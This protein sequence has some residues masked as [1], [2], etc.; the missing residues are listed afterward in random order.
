LWGNYHKFHLE[1][2][3]LIR[4][5]AL[6]RINIRELQ[7]KIKFHTQK[8]QKFGDTAEEILSSRTTSKSRIKSDTWPTCHQKRE[9]LH[10][11]S[12]QTILLGLLMK[13]KKCVGT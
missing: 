13:V 6:Q 1:N 5:L 7:K 9:I 8:S 12:L 10:Q 3:I 11:I 2:P 4:P